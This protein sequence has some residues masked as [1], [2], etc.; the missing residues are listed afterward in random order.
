M[1]APKPSVEK[2]IDNLW[3]YQLRREHSAL[4]DT[5]EA[6]RAR[7]QGFTA[8]A[9]AAQERLEGEITSMKAELFRISN[10]GEKRAQNIK[11]D[12]SIVE[13]K[14]SEMERLRQDLRA[15]SERV[16]DLERVHIMRDQGQYL[17]H[18]T[19]LI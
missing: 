3:Q 9:R 2:A 6:E 15:L 17:I 8:E 11:H 16:N 13:A 10:E 1:A 19:E 18:T 12:L 14:A 4:L 7:W 5:L